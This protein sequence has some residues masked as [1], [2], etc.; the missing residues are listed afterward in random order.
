MK[1]NLSGPDITQA[2]R[3]AALAVLN[4]RQLSLGP[5]VPEFEEAVARFVGTA[6]AIAVSSGTAGLH[7]LMRAIGIGPGDEVITTPFSFVASSNCILFERGRPVFVDIDAETWNIDAPRIE[8]AVTPKT[9][10]L[11]PVDVFGAVPDMGVIGEIA[12]RHGLRV[13]ED[14][15]EALGHA[16]P[17]PDGRL[18]R[19]R[20]SVRLLSQQADYDGRR[21]HDRHR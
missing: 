12:E 11:I 4:T 18:A 14:S 7:L 19:G 16:V 5:R 13:I 6:H 1:I 2:E 10:A 17:R 9:K 8:S 20:R 21:R 15:C 3:D